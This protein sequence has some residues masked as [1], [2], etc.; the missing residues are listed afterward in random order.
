[1]TETKKEQIIVKLEEAKIRLDKILEDLKMNSKELS[2][3]KVKAEIEETLKDLKKN[4]KNIK[5]ENEEIISEYL[6]A[7]RIYPN[8]KGYDYL[9]AAIQTI[10]NEPSYMHNTTQLYSIVAKRFETNARAIE[11]R[12][13]YEIGKKL[14]DEANKEFRDKFFAGRKK[15]TASEFISVLTEVIRGDDEIG[16]ILQKLGIMPNYNGYEYLKA[17]V[18]LIMKNPDLLLMDVNLKVAEEFDTTAY[19]V[20]RNIRVAIKS[21]ASRKNFDFFMKLFKDTKQPTN[22]KFITTVAMYIKNK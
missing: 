15:V 8:T 5:S 6:K 20:D 19:C 12:I 7:L 10:I 2:E 1:M 11:K 17:A 22:K 4:L 21:S 18:H 16:R 13:R 3:E 14:P 9:E